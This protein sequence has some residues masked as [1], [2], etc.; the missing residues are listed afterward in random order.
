M[1]RSTLDISQDC[2]I[3]TWG[4]GFLELIFEK[5]RWSYFYH[6]HRWLAQEE[7]AWLLEKDEEML[8]EL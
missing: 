4:A 7:E 6:P 8:A 3:V 1:P 5:G 2:Y